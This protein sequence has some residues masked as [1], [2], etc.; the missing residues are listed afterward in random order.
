MIELHRKEHVEFDLNAF[1]TEILMWKTNNVPDNRKNLKMLSCKNC[2]MRIKLAF[3]GVESF[4]A[5]YYS[6][7][8]F[9]VTMQK[10]PFVANNRRKVIL[11]HNNVRS[12]I[13]KSVKQTFLE[14]EWEIF[15]HP[16]YSPN[17]VSS[18]YHFFRLMQHSL[19]NTLLQLRRSLK[20]E[21]MDHFK[22]HRV[23]PWDCQRDGKK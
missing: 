5:F 17:L 23:L 21:W 3:R 9:W 14:L 22:R 10:R 19:T 6:N 15:P 11:L 20:M 7:G 1:E 16:M 4:N 13:V 2:S 8:S 12:H 18:D